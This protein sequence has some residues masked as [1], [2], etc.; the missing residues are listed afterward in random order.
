M[1]LIFQIEGKTPDPFLGIMEGYIQ[2]GLNQISTIELILVSQFPL[3]DDQCATYVTKKSTRKERNG[4][5]VDYTSSLP[6]L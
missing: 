3:D 6:S 1:E 4:E 2:E 5:T